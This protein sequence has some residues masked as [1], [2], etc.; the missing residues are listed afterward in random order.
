MRRE[1]GTTAE[2]QLDPHGKGYTIYRIKTE[3][4]NRDAPPSH[5]SCSA[6]PA[7]QAGRARPFSRAATVG[8]FIVAAACAHHRPAVGATTNSAG[9]D[10]ATPISNYWVAVLTPLNPTP[11]IQGRADISLDATRQHASVLLFLTGLQTDKAYVWHIRHG[12]C[13]PTEPPGPPSEY[14]PLT[15]DPHGRGTATGTFPV[16]DPDLGAY[17]IDV[18]PA[19]TDSIAHSLATPDVACGV[20]MMRKR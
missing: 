5:E 17:H 9:G 2:H 14:A 7:M 3:S 18:H 1:P 13:S 4:K 8:L 20:I 12:P 15:V 6:R 10:V 16:R 11:E 19:S